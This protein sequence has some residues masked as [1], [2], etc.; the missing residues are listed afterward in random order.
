[1]LAKSFSQAVNSFPFFPTNQDIPNQPLD[2]PRKTESI[3]LIDKE[4]NIEFVNQVF[5]EGSGYSVEEALNLNFNSIISEKNMEFLYKKVWDAISSGKEWNGKL[6]FKNKGGG[7]DLFE[8]TITPIKNKSG[9][10]VHFIITKNI[11]DES[12]DKSKEIDNLLKLSYFGNI[13]CSLMHELK[14]HFALIRMNFNQLKPSSASEKN[15]YSIIDRDL[16]RVTKLF[17]NFSQFSKVKEM[18]LIELNIRNVIE[19]SFASIKTLLQDKKIK[20]TNNVEPSVIK[21]DYQKLKCLFKNLIEN[22]IDAIEKEG[23]IVVSSKKDDKYLNIYFKDNGI[24]IKNCDKVFEPFY[25]T[26]SKGTGLGL[27]IVKKIIEE[28]KG[29]INLLKFKEGETIFELKYPL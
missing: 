10:I 14:S 19:Y 15:V 25:T 8:T 6:Q 27:A 2:V 5:S 22:A 20:F 3:I 18:E 1:M 7:S 9:E 16:E 12:R 28:H 24:G 26:K 11:V 17:F 4:G 23:E 29:M 13:F 21:G